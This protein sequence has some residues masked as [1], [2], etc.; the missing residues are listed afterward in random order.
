MPGRDAHLDLGKEKKSVRVGKKKNRGG[1]E[2]KKKKKK[3]GRV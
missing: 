3:I 1:G 2:K